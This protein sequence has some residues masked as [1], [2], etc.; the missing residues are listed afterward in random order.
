MNDSSSAVKSPEV[1]IDKWLWAVRLYKTRNLARD[2]CDAGHVKIAGNS[3]KP[4]RQIRVGET[5]E[6][7]TPGGLRVLE[8][9]ILDDRRGPPAVARTLYVD[10]SPPPPPKPEIPM[11]TRDRGVGR[12]SKR[13][14]RKLQKLRGY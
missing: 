4:S 6:A 13:D 14:L 8:V 9:L 12:P 3:V 2:A 10:H 7:R 5:V 1:R 11:A